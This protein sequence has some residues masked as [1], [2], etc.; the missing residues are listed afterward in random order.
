MDHEGKEKHLEEKVCMLN[1]VVI[2]KEFIMVTF[3]K[4]QYLNVYI[5]LY[6]NYASVHVLKRNKYV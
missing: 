4:V 1:L 5:L 3:T 2:L 6:M